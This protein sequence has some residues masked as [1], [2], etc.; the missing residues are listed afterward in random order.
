MI[1]VPGSLSQE[2]G[3]GL[4]AQAG[5][6]RL[7]EVLTAGGFTRAPPRHRDPLQPGPRSA[8]LKAHTASSLSTAMRELSS[9]SGS[10]ALI[11]SADTR[12]IAVN[13]IQ[14]PE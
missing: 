14:A 13:R 4:G 2:V 11:A 3:R 7:S 6:G 8:P 12:A 9:P 10:V 5:E 1:C